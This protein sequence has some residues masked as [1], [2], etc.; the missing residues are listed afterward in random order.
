[1]S[2]ELFSTPPKDWTPEQV[3]EMI[4]KLTPMVQKL[5]AARGNLYKE[6][7]DVQSRAD[8]LAGVLDPSKDRPKRKRKTKNAKNDDEPPEIVPST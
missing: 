5:R 8:V 6:Q 4:D 1:M 7:K 3:Q 2:K